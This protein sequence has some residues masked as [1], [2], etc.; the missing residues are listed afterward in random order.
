MRYIGRHGVLEVLL[1]SELSRESDSSVSQDRIVS[2]ILGANKIASVYYETRY[3][4][5]GISGG[6]IWSASDAML[7][8]ESQ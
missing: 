5:S 1:D 4:E 2:R 6:T 3:G 8:L 7:R